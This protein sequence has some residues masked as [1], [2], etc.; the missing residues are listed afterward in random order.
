MVMSKK[1]RPEYEALFK[2]IA[3]GELTRSQAAEIAAEQTGL[4][5]GTFLVWVSRAGAKGGLDHVKGSAGPNSPRSWAKLDPD[6]AK[7][8]EAAMEEALTSKM[9]VLHISKK[10]GVSYPYL[11]QKVNTEKIRRGVEENLREFE[12]HHGAPGYEDHPSQPRHTPGMLPVSTGEDGLPTEIGGYKVSYGT[13]KQDSQSDLDIVLE[14]LK[15]PKMV[16][17]FATLARAANSLKALDRPLY[18]THRKGAGKRLGPDLVERNWLTPVAP[19]ETT[20]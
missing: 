14:A 11:L 2:R 5:Q 7:A 17:R 15:D 9:S 10:H 8:Y 1:E 16:E 18:L 13:S 12:E 20:P 4:S 6:K 3:A 19:G